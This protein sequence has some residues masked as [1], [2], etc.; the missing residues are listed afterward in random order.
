MAAYAGALFIRSE[1]EIK[2][3]VVLL[4][5]AWERLE[6]R[7]MHVP[8]VHAC[9]TPRDRH[10]SSSGVA[11]E[12]SERWPLWPGACM[13]P[14]PPCHLLPRLQG[15]AQ[16]CLACWRSTFARRRCRHRSAS[17]AR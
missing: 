11:V 5:G 15:S 17:G 3:P 8:H 14:E 1:S 9:I 16:T 10:G 13:R 7:C 2:R 6:G 12:L 4:S